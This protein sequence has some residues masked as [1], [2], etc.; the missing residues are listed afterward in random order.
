MSHLSLQQADDLCPD[1]SIS[2][3]MIVNELE[4]RDIY[5]NSESHTTQG[6]RNSLPSLIAYF[7]V[8]SENIEEGRAFLKVQSSVI[9]E[10]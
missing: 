5:S 4:E 8:N 3:V 10:Y 9:H 7:L 2:Q 1:E 6:A